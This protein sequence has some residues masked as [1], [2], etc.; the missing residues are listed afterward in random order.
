MHGLFVWY[1]YRMKETDITI[2]L[3]GTDLN[4]YGVLRGD[5][6]KPLVILCHGYG[7][8]MNEMLLYNAARYFEKEGFASLRLSMYGGGE[9]S[10]DISAS[11]VLTHANDMDD[12][13]S[14]VKDKGAEQVALVGHSF[15][16]LAIVYSKKQQFDAAILWDPTHTDAYKDPEAIKSIERDFLFV[17]KLNAYVSGKGSGYVYAKTVFDNDFPDSKEMAAKF[18]VPTCVVNADWSEDQQRLGKAYVNDISADAKQ[19]IIPGSSHPFTEEG[20]AERLFAAT[21]DYCREVLLK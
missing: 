3:T 16:G 8:W 17:D 6:A 5:Y 1:S 9:H 2:P 13:V 10:R 15:S 14:Y 4:I 12:V 18:H 7:G 19:V 20:A 21:V 11:D